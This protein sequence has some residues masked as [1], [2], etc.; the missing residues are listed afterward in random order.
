M[1]LQKDILRVSTY[2][3]LINGIIG[4]TSAKVIGEVGEI[5]Q[6]GRAVYFCIKDKDQS[7]LNCIMWLSDYLLLGIEIKEGMEIVA[8]GKAEVYK[9]TGRLTFKVKTI[10]L[11]GEGEL[12]KAYEKLKA[13]LAEEGF[14]DLE[15]KKPLPLY[16]KKIGLL[17]SREGAVIHDFLN[18]LS[19][20]GFEI[21]FVNTRVEGARAVPELLDALN[22]FKKQNFDALVVIRGGGSLESFIPFNNEVII[23]EMKSLHFP[24]IAGIGH[25]KDV[26]LFS[27][28][29]DI[30]VSTPTAVTALLNNSWNEATHILN[31]NQHKLISHIQSI[32]TNYIYQMENYQRL[33]SIELSKLRNT[34]L[35]ILVKYEQNIFL[36]FQNLKYAYHNKIDQYKNEMIMIFVK[37][38]QK[39]N[40]L[41]NLAETTLKHADPK[42][43]LNL[44]YSIATFKGKIIR[45]I[46][47]IKKDQTIQTEISDGTFKSRVTF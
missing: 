29:A 38:L 34:V 40:S 16:P 3:D 36:N 18:N 44:G 22:Y 25:D 10:E 37:E 30:M 47:Q 41:I 6:H 2:L 46:K 43:Q 45:S 23:R 21:N 27:L 33:I 20:R 24:V 1:S 26:P 32:R 14:F 9:P 35:E 42:R 17:T 39:T 4:Y 31:L 12:K 7:M 5:K 19:K 28:A 11:V 15:L 13:K 8:E